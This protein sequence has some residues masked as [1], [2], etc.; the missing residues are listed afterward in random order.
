MVN[1]CGTP[2]GVAPISRGLNAV[3]AVQVSEPLTHS[4]YKCPSSEILLSGVNSQLDTSRLVWDAG[5]VYN[6]SLRK[7]LVYKGI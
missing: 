4:V 5:K 3:M 1:L 6:C 7:L 2:R